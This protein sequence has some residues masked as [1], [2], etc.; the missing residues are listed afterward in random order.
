MRT[1]M[2]TLTGAAVAAALMLGMVS[3][4]SAAPADARAKCAPGPGVCHAGRYTQVTYQVAADGRPSEFTTYA[5][6]FLVGAALA[7]AGGFGIL[8]PPGQRAAVLLALLA[9]IGVGIAGLAAGWPSYADRI[10]ADAFMRTFFVSSIV[11]FAT[12][13]AGLV[14]A[15]RRAQPRAAQI[16]D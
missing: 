7:L 5:S 3:A 10:A 14:L 8:L 15:W 2:K 4:S 16:G 1:T 12:V 9:G 11:G 6:L 13:V